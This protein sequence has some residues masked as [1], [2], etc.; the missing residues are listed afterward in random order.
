MIYEDK[1]KL[2]QIALKLKTKCDSLLDDLDGNTVVLDPVDGKSIDGHYA[3]SHLAVGYLLLWKIWDDI[4]AQKT[5]HLLLQSIVNRWDLIT[6]ERDFH[7]DFN[8]FAL[9][10]AYHYIEDDEL[11]IQ[12]KNLILYTNDSLHETV[13]WLPMR[14]YVNQFRYEITG[15]IKY[16]NKKEELIKKIEKATFSDFYIDDRIPTG[17]SYNVQY[18]IATV[19]ALSMLNIDEKVLD[20]SKF[21]IAIEKLVLPDGDINYLGRGCN[22]IFAWG[23]W[24]YL[25][26]KEDSSNVKVAIDYLFSHISSI[27]E[28]NNVLLNNMAGEERWLWW[29][30]HHFSVY[31]SHLFMWI[32][33]ALEC[34]ENDNLEVQSKVALATGVNSASG[35]ICYKN[36]KYMM[37]L[38]NGRKEYLSET[39]PAI[40]ALWTKKSGTIFKG[41]FAPWFGA[42]GNKHSNSFATILNYFGLF[43]LQHDNSHAGNRFLRKLNVIEQCSPWL[44]IKPVYEKTSVKIDDEKISITFDSRKKTARFFNVPSMVKNANELF[45]VYADDKEMDLRSGISINNQY[46]RCDIY[47]TEI[48]LATKWHFEISI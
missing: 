48:V 43:E 9:S 4:E 42:F 25:L 17:I 3:A 10:L 38:F 14:A 12:I 40:Y 6:A 2:K 33:L 1:E 36:E 23:P 15:E 41:I 21:C 11:L 46:G 8:L 44:R 30:Y 19:A 13:N 26:T 32:M 16:K 27:V 24:I 18:N 34:K 45:K 20:V 29:D 39:G 47:Q 31:I 37:V 22:Q 5:A 28:N 35:V 7:A